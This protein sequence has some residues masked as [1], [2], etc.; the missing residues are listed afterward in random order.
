GSIYFSMNT[1]QGNPFDWDDTLRNDYYRYP[2][3]IPPMNWIDSTRPERP[4]LSY[5]SSQVA[6]FG[7]SLEL[8]VRADSADPLLNRFVIYQFSDTSSMDFNK[9]QHITSILVNPAHDSWFHLEGIPPRQDVVVIA[10]TA[11]RSTNTESAP[12]RYIYL[13]RESNGWHVLPVGDNR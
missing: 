5:D 4:V 10:A 6:I 3:I 1:F 7:D 13:K 2:A 8:F 9:P 11:L 12:S